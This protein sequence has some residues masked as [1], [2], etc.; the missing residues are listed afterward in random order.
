MP[1]KTKEV[2]ED[3]SEE[4]KISRSQHGALN[5]LNMIMFYIRKK[6]L[7]DEYTTAI[8]EMTRE[9]LNELKAL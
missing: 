6:N 9:I 4:Q 2:K 7:S 3:K 8:E 5:N 1:K